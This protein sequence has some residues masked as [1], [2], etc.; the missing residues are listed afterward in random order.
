MSKLVSLHLRPKGIE[1]G[2]CVE[3]KGKAILM[4]GTATSFPKR[5]RK[6]GPA[7]EGGTVYSDDR[8]DQK[9]ERWD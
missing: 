6:S 4:A 5:E 8:N 1:K 7:L 3:G 9:K 2:C